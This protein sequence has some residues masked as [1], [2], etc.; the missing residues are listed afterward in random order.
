[1]FGTHAGLS[2]A[3]VQKE[4]DLGVGKLE[5]YDPPD[6]HVIPR[7]RD[8][9]VEQ[10]ELLCRIGF[11]FV[12]DP[13]T[14]WDKAKG[15]TFTNLFPVPT[16]VNEALVSRFGQLD[17]ALWIETSSPGLIG[18]SGGP[19]ADTDGLI[20][21]I[22]VNTHHYPLGFKGNAQNQTMNVG[23]AVHV[24]TVKTFLNEHGI[25]HAD[26]PHMVDCLTPCLDERHDRVATYGEIAALAV[27]A[28]RLDKRLGTARMLAKHQAVGAVADHVGLVCG[29]CSSPA[30]FRRLVLG[31]GP[32]EQP[33]RGG[34]R[35]GKRKLGAGLE[36]ATFPS[37]GVSTVITTARRHTRAHGV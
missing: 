11:P 28:R 33:R 3:L 32:R 20:C 27:D 36:K 13:G 23:R 8:H 17:S 19:L 1:M 31:T 25:A 15:F 10:G 37:V 7:F 4:V 30:V 18:Q 12:D 24:D 21:G 5:G 6:G 26:M 35:V 34:R 16:F 2:K 22:Q 14:K 9:Q 29:H